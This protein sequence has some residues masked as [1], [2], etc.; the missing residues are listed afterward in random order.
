[1]DRFILIEPI[2]IGEALTF[3]SSIILLII[4]WKSVSN[5][6]KA[7]E[8]TEQSLQLQSNQFNLS[9]KPDLIFEIPPIKYTEEENNKTRIGSFIRPDHNFYV[10][11]LSPN[12]CY[13]ISVTTLIYM[14][15]KGWDKYYSFLNN[16][17]N[18]EK[19]RPNIISHNT[20]HSL[21]STN[22]LK[23]TI[24]FYYL[25]LN[26]IA[27]D[28][29]ITSPDLYVFI[30]YEDKTR[31]SYEECFELKNIGR[32]IGKVNQPD[33]LEID[34]IPIQI[35]KVETKKKVYKQKRKLEDDFPNNQKLFYYDL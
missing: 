20:I 31:N 3:L 29:T 8:I 15:D 16:E 30:K 33:E 12:I 7:N 9:I 18:K 13:N 26:I 17:F 28:G 1:M 5:A 22:E 35:D 4:T 2:S 32:R 10:K 23:C 34:F 21:H 6:K 11:N 19:S 27:Y 24:P 14:P 25:I